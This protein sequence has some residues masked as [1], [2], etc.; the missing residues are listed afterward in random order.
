M[1]IKC[2]ACGAENY[3]TGLEEEETR[4]CNSCNESLFKIG[5]EKTYNAFLGSKQIFDSQG[6]LERIQLGI[7]KDFMQDYLY[8]IFKNSIEAANAIRYLADN[9]GIDQNKYDLSNTKR[10]SIL[11]EFIY[12]YLHLT[13]RFAFGHMN[14]ERRGSL[15][16]EL[17]EISI[18]TAVDAVCLRWPEDIKEKIKEECMGNFYISMAEYSKCKKWH[19]EKDEGAKGTLFWEFDKTIA[20]LVGQEWESGFMLAVMQ[21]VTNSLKDLDIKSFINRIKVI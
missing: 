16:T 1:K 14:E 12:F 10:F 6:L 18:T 2:P 9:K 15:M 20:K 17:E 5:K 21:I 19:P 7:K 8:R 4:F 13:D 3:F 11:F